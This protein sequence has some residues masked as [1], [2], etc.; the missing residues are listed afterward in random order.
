MN[1]TLERGV[2]RRGYMD[3]VGN[4]TWDREGDEDSAVK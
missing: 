2:F 3:P 4:L 1:S